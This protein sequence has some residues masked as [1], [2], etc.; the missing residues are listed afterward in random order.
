[1]TGRGMTDLA[2]L[3]ITQQGPIA[4][5][6]IVQALQSLIP[7]LWYPTV[8]VIE[9]AI[10]RNVAELNLCIVELHS[11]DEALTLTPKGEEKLEL[12]LKSDPGDLE[13]VT[14]VVADALQFC[15]LDTASAKT[16]E[17]VLRRLKDR[18][19]RRLAE[20][21]VRSQRCPNKGH[22]TRLWIGME[23]RRLEAVSQLIGSINRDCVA[24]ASRAQ[25]VTNTADI[26]GRMTN[27]PTLR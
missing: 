17:Y 26:L 27:V 15:F 24:A 14:P 5:T 19:D 22:F 25:A 6:N 12:L 1:M 16:V 7:E 4:I 21:S 20:F 18:A 10:K 23:Q 9:G 11:T 3:G 13:G 2:L 8:S